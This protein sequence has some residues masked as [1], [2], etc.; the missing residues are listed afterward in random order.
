[1]I[2]AKNEAQSIVS[3]ELL[4]AQFSEDR[5]MV[6]EGFR[7]TEDL[8]RSVLDLESFEKPMKLPL[9]ADILRRLYEE[10]DAD[11]LIYTNVDIGLYPN[12]YLEVNRFINQ[13]LDAFIINRRRLEAKFTEVNQLKDIYEEKG[14]KHPGFDCFVFK[15]ELYPEIQLA[16]VCIGVPFIEITFGQNL[17]ALA[18]NFK[19]F[20]NEFLTFHI[21]ME[22]FKG[23]APRSYFRYNRKQFWKAINSPLNDKLST[24]K[25]PYGN[26]ILPIRLIKWGLHPCLPIRLALKL[27]FRNLFGKKTDNR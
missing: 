9:I 20:E 17:F 10:S 8:D 4:T 13:G 7:P 23:R 14:K 12:F 15:R 18:K 3:I 27:E 25:W 26:R 6:V 2:R 5:N 19:L 11:Y 21:G 1:M 16:D 22:I 24:K